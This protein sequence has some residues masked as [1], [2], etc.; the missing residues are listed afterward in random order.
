MKLAT[1]LPNCSG[2]YR[3]T[4]P[5]GSVYIGQSRG[6]RYRRNNHLSAYKR[7]KSSTV[8]KRSFDK[9]GFDKHIFEVIHELP[10]DV[11]LE[12]LNTYELFYIN[13]YKGA[14]ILVLNS[15]ESSLGGSVTDEVRQKLRTSHLGQK[16]WNKGKK[17]SPE[18]IAKLKTAQLGWKRTPESIAKRVLA[19]TGK[20]RTDETKAR[21]SAALKGKAGYKKGIHKMNDNTRAALKKSLVGRVVSEETRQ[22]IRNTL[23]SKK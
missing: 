6:I 19:T 9:Y 17:L 7:R 3:I 21:M 18:H 10:K 15:G 5:S 16:A 23:L 8:L 2:I 13:A 1:S 12:I 20:K 11:S 14:G 22:K 4:S